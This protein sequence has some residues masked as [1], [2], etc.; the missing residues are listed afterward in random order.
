MQKDLLIVVICL[1][2]IG[3]GYFMAVIEHWMDNDFPTTKRG[4]KRRY[5]QRMP[6]AWI[7]LDD[8]GLEREDT[9]QGEEF[10]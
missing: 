3:L 10:I 6:R 1:V 4:Y 2:L 9:H 8:K 7:V 5:K